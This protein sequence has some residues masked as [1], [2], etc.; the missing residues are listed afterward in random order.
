VE[1]KAEF[2]NVAIPVDAYELL[3]TVADKEERTIARQL[4]FLIRHQ[5]SQEVANVD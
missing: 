2:R 5:Y 4:A 1:K 3:R